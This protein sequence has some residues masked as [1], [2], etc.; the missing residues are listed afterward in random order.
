MM[1]ANLFY[2]PRNC[3][4]NLY[5]LVLEHVKKLGYTWNQNLVE[6]DFIRSFC[7]SS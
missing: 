6:L 1:L 4:S 7:N 3:F 2:Y 5:T